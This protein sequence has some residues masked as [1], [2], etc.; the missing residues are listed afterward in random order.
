MHHHLCP[1]CGRVYQCAVIPNE[2]E[3]EELCVEV[4]LGCDN[5]GEAH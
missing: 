3:D 1:T 5:E 4:C 2:G